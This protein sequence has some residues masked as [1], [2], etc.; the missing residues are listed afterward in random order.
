MRSHIAG[1]DLGGTYIKTA[2]VSL[3]G[4]LIHKIEIP[5]EAEKGPDGVIENICNSIKLAA[6]ESGNDIS[7]IK[8]IGIGSPGPLNTEKG[9][10]CNAVNLPGWIDIPLRDK[11]QNSFGIPVNLEND[12]NAAAYG[13][14][15]HGAGEGASIMVAFTLGTGVGGGIIIRGHLLR[16]SSDGA[17][18]LG[19]MTI[20][21]NGDICS[22]GN[23]G[24]LESYASATALV[25]RTKSKLNSGADSILSKWISEGKILSAKLINDAHLSNDSFATSCFE[26][27][28]YYLG[29]GVANVVTTLNP[30]IVVIGGGMIKAGEVIMKPVRREVKKR[31]FDR[32]SESLRIVPARLGNDAGMIGA[33]GLV[34]ER[35]II[36]V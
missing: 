12:A 33:A 21:P 7:S 34:I 18:E 2:L 20:V 30:D 9:I 23:Y 14:Y 5:S 31:I 16:G 15:W 4:E 35:G 25:R 22:C 28:A 26:E 11:L 3:S 10:V 27:A 6:K 17:G 8:A 36:S 13:E 24:C 1:V 29:I 19:H 32:L